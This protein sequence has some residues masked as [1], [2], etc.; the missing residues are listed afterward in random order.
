MKINKDTVVCISLAK[1][2]GNFGCN[3]HNTL[4]DKYGLNY[5]YKSFSVSD[6]KGAIDG[7]RALG[8]RGAG[9]T[10]PYKTQV[11]QHVDVLSDDVQNIGAANTIVN[12]E[13]VLTAYNT[14]AHSSHIVIGAAAKESGHSQIFILGNGGFSRAVRYSSIKLALEISDITRHNW[15]DIKNI[16]DSIVFNCTPVENI[17]LI[18]DSS[19]VFIDC[20]TSTPT[21][22]R[23]ATLQGAKQFYLYTGVECLLEKF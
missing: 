1:K 10:M 7:I 23:L 11:L 15:D 8:I 22:A 9:V 3:F 14:D 21:G 16:R 5:I 20:L 19:C 2:A 17:D 6:I 18:I 13:G 4:F 12:D